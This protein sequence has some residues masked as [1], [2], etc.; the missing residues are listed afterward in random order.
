MA[1]RIALGSNTH[2]YSPLLPYHSTPVLT[3]CPGSMAPSKEF[4]I[5]REQSTMSDGCPL[6]SSNYRTVPSRL[7][8]CNS[9]PVGTLTVALSILFVLE[10][11]AFKRVLP[12][13]I[14]A[15]FVQHNINKRW[16]TSPEARSPKTSE[17]KLHRV[18]ARRFRAIWQGLCRRVQVQKEYRPKIL[19]LRNWT[20]NPSDVL[21]AQSS[22]LFLWISPVTIL[23]LYPLLPTREQVTKVLS[24]NLRHI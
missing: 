21:Q 1:R 20:I 18:T 13:A 5:D 7:N 16:A 4:L 19:N 14:L 15:S 12:L 17:C 23:C 9:S 6:Q 8:F 3:M 22:N 11:E 24:Q 2:Y 10:S